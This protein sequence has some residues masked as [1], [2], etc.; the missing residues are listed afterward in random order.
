MTEEARPAFY[1]LAPGGWRDYVTL[2]HLPYTA[3]HLSFL[4]IG[5]ALAPEFHKGRLVAQGTLQSVVSAVPLAQ[6]LNDAFVHL[7][8]E[9]RGA[10]PAPTAT[11]ERC[12]SV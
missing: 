8:G 1:A 2:L 5:A 3:W 4:V 9:G 7:V 12:Q 10:R 11:Y 6:T